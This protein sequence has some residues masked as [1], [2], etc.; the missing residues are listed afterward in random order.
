MNYSQT[1]TSEE[2]VDDVVEVDVDVDV[3]A[4]DDVEVLELLDRRRNLIGLA[5]EP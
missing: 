4:E 3:D 1:I 2:F 5:Q